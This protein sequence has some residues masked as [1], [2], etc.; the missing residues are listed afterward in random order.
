M[1]IILI[2]NRAR[3]ERHTRTRKSPAGTITAIPAGAGSEG[4]HVRCLH[5]GVHR[6]LCHPGNVH[7]MYSLAAACAARFLMLNVQVLH[8]RCMLFDEGLARLHE[9]AHERGENVFRGSLV[10]G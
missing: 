6:L 3:A 10:L 8:F 2:K 7:A 4:D 9:V 1:Y 5:D